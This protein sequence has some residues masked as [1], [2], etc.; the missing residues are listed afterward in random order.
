MTGDV[1]VITRTD[2]GA[3]ALLPR[4]TN[5]HFNP[6]QMKSSFY[7]FRMLALSV[8]LTAGAACSASDNVTGTSTGGSFSATVTGG[9]AGS[10]SGLASATVLGGVANITLGTTDTKFAL[11]FTRGG[12][13][14]STGTYPLGS[15]LLSVF[16]ASISIN[17]GAA[18]YGSSGGT[19]TITTSSATE[20]KGSFDFP[21]KLEN[22]TTTNAVKGTFSAVC[23]LGC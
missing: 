21:G 10:Y 5:C 19:L 1:E 17:N 15:N 6:I 20:I 2:P 16:I 7:S 4:T 23:Q 11:A 18:I 12:A 14:P 8:L 22:G 13:R 3:T 9:A